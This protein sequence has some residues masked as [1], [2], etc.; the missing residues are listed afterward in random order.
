MENR[1]SKSIEE[2]IHQYPAQKRF[3]LA[4]MQDIQKENNYIPKE[5]LACISEYIDTPICKLYGIAT[6][7]K[8]FSLKPKGKYIIKICAGTACHIRSSMTILSELEKQLNVKAGETTT[9]GLFSLETVNCVGACALAPVV[10][11]NEEYY[12]KVTPQDIKT[13]LQKYKRGEQGEQR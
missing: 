6:F 2:I 9:D 10:V 13:I 5:A 3:T 7:F 4:M 1:I 8:A 12:G 11:I